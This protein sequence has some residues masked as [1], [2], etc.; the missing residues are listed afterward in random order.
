MDN[1]YIDDPTLGNV[2]DVLSSLCARD[3]FRT[4]A[5]LIING[6]LNVIPKERL[7][8]DIF[9]NFINVIQQTI[10]D[11]SKQFEKTLV[12]Q[13]IGLLQ[14]IAG[15][16]RHDLVQYLPQVMEILGHVLRSDEYTIDV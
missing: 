4:G 2:F 13:S 16:L 6:V 15:S 12:R 7:S 14:D 10:Y 5:L 9:Q 11:E 8:A 3:V 1:E